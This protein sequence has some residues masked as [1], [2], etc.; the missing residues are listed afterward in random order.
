MHVLT[1]VVEIYAG[2]KGRRR[3]I[4]YHGAIMPILSIRH[5][6]AY[7]YNR[8]VAFGEHRMMLR[9][10]D[11]DDQRIIESELEITPSPKQLAWTKDGF[12]NHVA[13]AHFDARAGELRFAS[14]IRLDHAPGEFRA[15][16]IKD[17]ARAYP[18][19]YAPADWPDLEPFIRPLSPH[20]A[21]D[22][23]SGAFFRKDGS[24]DTFDL[25]GDMTRTIRRSFK[26]VARH[27]KGIQ[28]PAW[29]LK[30]G[31]GSCRDLA[32]LMIAALRT[33]GIAA[34]F[35]SGYLH[36]P[37]DDEDVVGGNT[38]AWV[39]VYVPGPGWV[40]F[41]P[42]GGAVGNKNLIRVAVAPDAREAVPLQGT[43]FGTAADHRA[44]KVA[45]KVT[46][47]AAGAATSGW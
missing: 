22:L 5:V 16:D 21:V 33:R 32:V 23:W 40:D 14:N 34:R 36:L 3:R 44:M 6:T 1:H 8:A 31:S 20:P 38:H 47:A 41:D 43:W 18:F 28:A 45:V 15:T 9:P 12:G 29:T 7:H 27:E 26:H 42:S 11:D 39:Q 24:A 35:V 19:S 2:G 10:R 25:L 30:L 37:D 46:T 17:F 13:I 4:H